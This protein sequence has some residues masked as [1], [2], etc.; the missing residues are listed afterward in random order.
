MIPSPVL[1]SGSACLTI[2]MYMGYNPVSST[3]SENMLKAL[4]GIIIHN[5]VLQ[6]GVKTDYFGLV[7][8]QGFLRRVLQCPADK[9]LQSDDNLQPP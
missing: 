1:S 6:I 4:I 7:S 9:K 3:S 8:F 2:Y 5:R